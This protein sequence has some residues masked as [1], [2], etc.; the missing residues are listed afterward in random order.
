[1]YICILVIADYLPVNLAR[2]NFHIGWRWFCFRKSQ[3]DMQIHAVNLVTLLKQ[4]N[5]S[6]YLPS[7]LTKEGAFCSGS[8]GSNIRYIYINLLV[9]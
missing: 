3:Y 4:K 7:H 5:N 9:D 2:L 1:M 8:A 6:Q